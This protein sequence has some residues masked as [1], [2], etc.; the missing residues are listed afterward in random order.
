VQRPRALRNLA[1]GAGLGVATALLFIGVGII[2]AVVAVISGARVA[3]PTS[4]DARILLFYVGGFAVAGAFLGVLL[5]YLH[6]KS[7]KYLGFA[8]GGVVVMLAIAAGDQGGLGALD[9]VDWIAL[10]ILGAILGL[11]A[12][13]GYLRNR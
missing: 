3:P 8:A 7:L 2:R 11:A 10:P 6:A 1:V 4:H 12:G 13:F 9:R 5:P